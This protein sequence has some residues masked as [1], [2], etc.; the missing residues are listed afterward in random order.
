MKQKKISE[1]EESSQSTTNTRT[2]GTF[3]NLVENSNRNNESDFVIFSKKAQEFKNRNKIENNIIISGVGEC[4]SEVPDEKEKHD[5]E[6]VHQILNQ[7]GITENK[8][9]RIARIKPRTV[10]ESV[11]NSPAK[12][13]ILLVELQ[14]CEKLLPN[15]N[16]TRFSETKKKERNS[17]LPHIETNVDGKTLRYKRDEVGNRWFWGIRNDT[18][19]WVLHPDDRK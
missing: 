12:E 7:I 8:C 10:Q 9:K 4:D 13:A 3:A 16:L 11:E 5:K 15:S 6:K 2:A 17:T 14:D 1:L 19:V 18:L